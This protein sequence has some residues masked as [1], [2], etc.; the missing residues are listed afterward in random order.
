MSLLHSDAVIVK[1]Y[2]AETTEEF[3][4]GHVSALA[5]FGGIP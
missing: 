1:S 2:P 4:D 5:F 3:F